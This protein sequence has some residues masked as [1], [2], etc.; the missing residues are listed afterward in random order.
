MNSAHL[1]RVLRTE[2]CPGVCCRALSACVSVPGRGGPG[3]KDLRSADKARPLCPEPC[4][5][6]VFGSSPRWASEEKT[7]SRR[8]CF[9]KVSN[10]ANQGSSSHSSGCETPAPRQARSPVPAWRGGG[11][12]ACGSLLG[13]PPG[14]H[15]C[16]PAGTWGNSGCHL[17]S[18]ACYFS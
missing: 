2:H 10:G 9:P 11:R 13:A 4:G 18:A 5:F 17:F 7:P 1:D 12:G 16:A 3:R 6:S 8:K 15:P 14:N